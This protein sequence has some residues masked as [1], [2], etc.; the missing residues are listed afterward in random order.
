MNSDELNQSNRKIILIFLSSVM[1][2]LVVSAVLNW[3]ISNGSEV[4]PKVLYCFR[5][6]F[7]ATMFAFALEAKVFTNSLNYNFHK[8]R[9]FLYLLF[10]V[11]L[12]QGVFSII[13]QYPA[14]KVYFM[15]LALI[16][17]AVFW[18]LTLKASWH[19]GNAPFCC[20][21][22]RKTQPLLFHFSMAVALLGLFAQVY[23]IFRS[24]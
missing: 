4:A 2:F 15:K 10:G 3:F 11:I 9:F 7:T 1:I 23:L 8:T 6:I 17:F 13:Q 5:G 18:W 19:T 14:S 20:W 24:N 22:N 16:L 12:W 21:V